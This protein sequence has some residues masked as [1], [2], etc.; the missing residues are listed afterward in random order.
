MV[1][2]EVQRGTQYTYNM[3]IQTSVTFGKIETVMGKPLIPVL[4]AMAQEV[5]KILNALEKEARTL[6]ILMT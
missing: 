6:S 2:A 5:E 4:K 3:E 1:L